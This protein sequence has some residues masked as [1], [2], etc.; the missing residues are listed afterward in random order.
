MISLTGVKYTRC[1]PA[2]FSLLEMLI[3]VA[4][5][6]VSMLVIAQ[7]F[8]SFNRLQRSLAHRAVLSQEVQIALELL[9]RAARNYPISYS[10]A[11]LAHDAQIRLM[12]ANGAEMIVKRSAV[13]ASECEDEPNVACLLLSLDGGVSWAPITAKHVN[14]VQFDAYV[15]PTQS[16]F[17]QVNGEYPNHIQ[18]F[19]T[20]HIG[21]KYEDGSSAQPDILHAQTSVTSRVYE[22]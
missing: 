12:Q 13:G 7:T 14:I 4:L 11:P 15:Y 9:V 22:R 17:V 5:F 2:G 8:T 20:F 1:R 21:A 10:P 6:S 18:P 16:P 19:V 3:V